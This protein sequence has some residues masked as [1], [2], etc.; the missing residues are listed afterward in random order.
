MSWSV[1]ICEV[2]YFNKL[3]LSIKGLP[4]WLRGKESICSMDSDPGLVRSSAKGNCNP[5]Q[6]SCLENPKDRGIWWATVHGLTRFGQNL[7]TNPPPLPLST[8]N[9]I[10]QAT[11]SLYY[12]W[13]HLIISLSIAIYWLTPQ[14]NV[15]FHIIQVMTVKIKIKRKL[16]IIKETTNCPHLCNQQCQEIQN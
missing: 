4:W 2:Y 15:E 12:K 11:F 1:Y 5:F 6:Y 7:V 9:L 16:I 10:S 8:K 3:L 13:K 14:K